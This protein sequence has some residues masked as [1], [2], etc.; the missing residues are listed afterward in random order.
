MG[1]RRPDEEDRVSWADVEDLESTMRAFW[2]VEIGYIW[3][4]HVDRFTGRTSWWCRAGASQKTDDGGL[5]TYWGGWGFRGSTGARTAAAA[6]LMALHK[7]G[8]NLAS[9]RSTG[10]VPPEDAAPPVH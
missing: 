1:A 2:G 5:R 8:D 6:M 7:L 9:G 4:R 3:T 10:A